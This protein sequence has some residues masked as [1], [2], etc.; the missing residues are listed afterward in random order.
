V[1]AAKGP[2]QLISAACAAWD[3]RQNESFFLI[4]KQAV[5]SGVKIKSANCDSRHAKSQQPEALVSQL[6]RAQNSISFEITGAAQATVRRNMNDA[7]PVVD[8][9]HSRL[10][11]SAK[12][13]D[14]LG[15][16]C[17]VLARQRYSLLI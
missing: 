3:R 4:T 7:Q 11:C 16:P 9:H 1:S 6:N 14:K 13:C 10:G 5:F 15:V 17:E 12:F 8:E 2:R